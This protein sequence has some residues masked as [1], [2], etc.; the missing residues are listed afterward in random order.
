L[1]FRSIPKYILK[2]STNKITLG[3]GDWSSTYDYKHNPRLPWYTSRTEKT[4][5]DM[6][7]Q[8]CCA[9]ADHLL[10]GILPFA[11]DSGH[12]TVVVT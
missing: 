4:M 1:N 12:T 3:L 5:F 10:E 8:G 9:R 7:K 2:Q 6:G 11:G